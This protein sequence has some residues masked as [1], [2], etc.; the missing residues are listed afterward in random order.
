[1]TTARELRRRARETLGHRIFGRSWLYALLACL[2][3]SLVSSAAST[4]IPLLGILLAG[5][6]YIGLVCY[7]RNL[8]ERRDD[9][10]SDLGTLFEA[11]NND[12]GGSILTGLLVNVFTVLWT[13]LF[14]IPGIVKSFSYGMTYYIKQE[15]PELTPRQAIDESRRMMDGHKLRLFC[16]ELSFV[17]WMFVGALTLGIGLLW[18]E[19]YMEAARYEFY[20]D[21]KFGGFSGASGDFGQFRERGSEQ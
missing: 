3:A 14:I 1:M 13:L 12:F 15:H 17:G 4:I 5:P 21:L 18:V 11:V 19:P 8:S 10:A 6:I 2:L 20:N 7:F 9:A 16:L